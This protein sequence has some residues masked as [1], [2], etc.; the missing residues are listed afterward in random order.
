MLKASH[1]VESLE[2]QGYDKVRKALVWSILEKTLLDSGIYH[3]VSEELKKKHHCHLDECY[4]H[5]EYL[6]TIL[7]DLY[8]NSS[9]HVIKSINNNLEEFSY[10][11]SISRFLK[12]ISQ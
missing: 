6:N 10:H 2:H 11:E 9:R 8:G 12:I 3:K 4:E 5:P 7:R 1:F